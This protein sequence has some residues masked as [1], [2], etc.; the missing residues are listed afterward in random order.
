MWKALVNLPVSPAEKLSVFL[1]NVQSACANRKNPLPDF[2][3]SLD[4]STTGPIGQGGQHVSNISWPCSTMGTPTDVM[5][6]AKDKD[7]RLNEKK[8]FST[9]SQATQLS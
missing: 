7:V 1:L 3:S 4:L 6:T 9:S 8:L 2:L 5:S